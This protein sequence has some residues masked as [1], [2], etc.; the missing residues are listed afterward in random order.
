M[1]KKEKIINASTDKII[2]LALLYNRWNDLLKKVFRYSILASIAVTAFFLVTAIHRMITA[3]DL[4]LFYRAFFL[5][6]KVWPALISGFL[7]NILPDLLAIYEI[8]AKRIIMILSFLW[9]VISGLVILLWIRLELL[10][11]LVYKK[12]MI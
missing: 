8:L 5:F 10:I 1:V 2:D 11:E 12:I 7:D 6:E 4:L 9:L 3:Q